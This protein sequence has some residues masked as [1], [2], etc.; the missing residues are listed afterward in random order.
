VGCLD[1]WTITATGFTPDS[2]LTIIG[3]GTHWSF[4]DNGHATIHFIADGPG[5]TVTLTFIDGNGVFASVT[6]GPT[7]NCAT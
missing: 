2:S 4:D 5:E 7:I 3:A 6:F 1:E